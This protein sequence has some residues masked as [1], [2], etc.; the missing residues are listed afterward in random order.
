M[1]SR[2][3]L[4]QI[5]EPYFDPEAENYEFIKDKIF[6]KGFSFKV[7]LR[8]FLMESEDWSEAKFFKYFFNYIQS[9]PQNYCRGIR[10]QFKI[11]LFKDESY[12]VV[13]KTPDNILIRDLNYSSIEKLNESI[14]KVFNWKNRFTTQPLLIDIE[15]LLINSP[16]EGLRKQWEDF[17]SIRSASKYLVNLENS[18]KK[19]IRNNLNQKYGYNYLQERSKF[20]NLVKFNNY[21][22]WASTRLVLRGMDNVLEA[23]FFFDEF[24]DIRDNEMLILKAQKRTKSFLCKLNSLR[25]NLRVIK[26]RLHYNLGWKKKIKLILGRK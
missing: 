2:E 17:E 22:L 7:D 5:L 25:D 12:Q 8:D 26:D 10:D 3:V 13:I 21:L 23:R 19:Q 16:D 9:P 4:K 11:C 15:I 24:M 20:Y 6:S 18:T 14:V 1:N